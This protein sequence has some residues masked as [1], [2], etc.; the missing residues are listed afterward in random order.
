MEGHHANEFQDRNRPVP[1]S[2]GTGPSKFKSSAPLGLLI[3]A[4]FYT[5]YFARAFLLPVT[6]ALLFTFLLRPVIR[7]LKKIRIP[8]MA[9]AALVLGILLGVVGYGANK[10]TGPAR[11]WIDRAP[12]GLRTMEQKVRSLIKPVEKASRTAEELKKITGAEG[13]GKPKVE[14]RSGPGLSGTVFAGVQAFLAKGLVMLILLFFLLASGDLFIHKLTRLFPRFYEK[15]QIVTIAREIER[16]VSRYLLTVTIINTLEGVAVSLSVYL[17]GMPNPVLWGVMAGFLVFIP[18]LGPLVGISVVGIA[19]LF[20]FESTGKALLVPAIYLAIEI[21]QGQI[22]TPVV[23]GARFALNPV[24]VFV[25]LI[26]WGW[27]WG[28]VGA[29]M[30]VPLLTVFKILCDHIRPLAPIGAFLGKE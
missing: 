11:D 5:L 22:I 23:L 24:A 19:A 21:L 4:G 12:E 3:L 25:W 8:E 27:I 10:L 15:V 6:L 14:V 7:A 16:S 18:Y 26:F 28:I 9:G 20:T 17:L 30:A 13:E 29:L 1:E 2:T